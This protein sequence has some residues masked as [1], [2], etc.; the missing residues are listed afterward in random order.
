MLATLLLLASLEIAY[1]A[2]PTTLDYQGF[3][4]DSAGAPVDGTV[5]ITFSIYDLPIGGAPWWTSNVPVTVNQGVFSV[6]LGNPV[7]PFPALMFDN[8]LWLGIAVDSDAEM[9]PRRPI[10]S[11]AFTYKAQDANTLEGISA[12]ALDQSAHISDTNNPH[13]VTVAQ[14]GAVST[15]DLANHAADASAHHTKTTSFTDLSDTATDEQIPNDITVYLASNADTVDGLNANSSP[16]AGRLLALDGGG[17]FPNST[18]IMW[19][20]SG[21]DA[22][23][24]DGVQANAFA[25]SAHAHNSLNAA[26]GNP[27]NALYV[28][29]NG[30]VGIGTTGPQ[31]DREVRNTLRLS[32]TSS[33]DYLQLR[34]TGGALDIDSYNQPLY[35]NNASGQETYIM[36][37]NVGIGT[38]TPQRVLS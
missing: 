7:T 33:S 30:W 32:E 16:V 10:V 35:I 3:L 37:G 28:N 26:D 14:T 23:T 38:S 9:F 15:A 13:N 2:P 4:T 12:S 18:L 21:L 31:A 19:S 20:G 11:T 25:P 36:G 5:N 8:P 1:A 6:Q 17:R 24:V 34:T 29:N 22:D 27:A